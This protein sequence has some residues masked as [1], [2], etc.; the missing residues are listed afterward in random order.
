MRNGP[1]SSRSCLCP[2]NQQTASVA[3]GF[4]NFCTGLMPFKHVLA[5]FIRDRSV[6]CMGRHCLLFLDAVTYLQ[7]ITVSIEEEMDY[8]NHNTIQ[9]IHATTLSCNFVFSW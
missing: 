7:I 9:H 5:V 1:H 8:D 6:S 4:T 2:L 3:S